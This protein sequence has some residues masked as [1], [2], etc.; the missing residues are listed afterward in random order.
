MGSRGWGLV[1]AVWLVALVLLAGC[2]TPPLTPTPVPIP[3][4]VPPTATPVPVASP[5]VPPLTVT[6]LPTRPLALPTASLIP[7]TSTP[8]PPSTPLATA[9]SAP[10]LIDIDELQFVDAL[11]GWLIGNQR[12]LMRSTSDG[13]RTWYSLP[14]PALKPGQGFWHLQFATT[15][16]GWVYGASLFATHD[17]GHTWQDAQPKG[18]VEMLTAAGNGVW[19]LENR[20]SAPDSYTPTPVFRRSTDTGRTWHD[21]TRQPSLQPYGQ[22][23]VAVSARDAFILS[24][25]LTTEQEVVWK[26]VATG[27]G[28]KAWRMLTFPDLYGLAMPDPHDGW[29]CRLAALTTQ[30]LWLLCVSQSPIKNRGVQ[31]KVLYHSG[32]GGQHWQRSADS[33]P[34]GLHNLLY[35]GYA[36]GVVAAT[37]DRLWIPWVTDN[38]EVGTRGF[39]IE[40][41]SDGGLTWHRMPDIHWPGWSLPVAYAG[42]LAAWVPLRTFGG[43]GQVP[44]NVLLHTTNGWA[45]WEKLL[46]PTYQP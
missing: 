24:L 25:G 2:D 42:A 46:W 45:T 26:L 44:E 4:P 19:L 10:V 17:G 11:H 21:V 16:D 38:V 30:Q 32:D 15:H 13:G 18:N 20:F 27:D 9:T 6:P 39:Q 36:S 37:P 12:Q 34:D 33:Y 23:L 8:V 41:T 31:A 14:T 35:E 43:G 1:G 22:Q 28:G 40:S 3:S 29:D 5:T 7:M